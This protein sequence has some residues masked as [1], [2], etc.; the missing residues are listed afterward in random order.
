LSPSSLR[1]S[2]DDASDAAGD[3]QNLLMA[4]SARGVTKDQETQRKDWSSIA[5]GLRTNTSPR[6]HT[7][8]PEQSLSR[9]LGEMYYTHHAKRTE[10]QCLAAGSITLLKVS[11]K[12][13]SIEPLRRRAY[14]RQSTP[15]WALGHFSSKNPNPIIFPLRP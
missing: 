11:T 1:D 15:T 4:G 2:G 5:L 3:P 8:L 7:F 13:G 12:C 14:H 9:W 10:Q 6:H